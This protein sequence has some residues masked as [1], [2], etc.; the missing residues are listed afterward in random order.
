MLKEVEKVEGFLLLH[1]ET[2][3]KETSCV[4]HTDIRNG[5]V[6]EGDEIYKSGRGLRALAPVALSSLRA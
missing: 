1:P 3:K 6:Q 4:S 5:D 2:S